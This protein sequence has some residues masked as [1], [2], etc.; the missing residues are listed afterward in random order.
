MD[1]SRVTQSLDSLWFYTNILTCRLQPSVASLTNQFE[2]SIHANEPPKRDHL[3]KPNTPLFPLNHSHQNA[4][5]MTPRCQ[6]GEISS[7][8]EEVGSSE[9]VRKSSGRET[10]KSRER[11][12][13]RKWKKF[14]V[15]GTKMILGGLDLGFNVKEVSGFLKFQESSSSSSPHNRRYQLLSTQQQAKLPPFD[16]DVAMKQHLKSWAYAVACTV[17]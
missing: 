14:G 9:M 3:Q 16:D 1:G 5:K 11:R 8:F 12:K 6:L 13:R 15:N 7:A 2:P 10:E 17:K 4:E